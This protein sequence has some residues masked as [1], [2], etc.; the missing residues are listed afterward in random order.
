MPNPAAATRTLCSDAEHGTIQS[1]KLSALH[2]THGQRYALLTTCAVRGQGQGQGQ[3]R[4][5]ARAR[6]T[7]RTTNSESPSLS[8]GRSCVRRGAVRLQSTTSSTPPGY[9]QLSIRL[10][11]TRIPHR[12]AC[13]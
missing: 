1:N 13:L 12:R 2:C 9:F 3:V 10:R 8:G 11:M 5:R 6:V 4:V 7:S